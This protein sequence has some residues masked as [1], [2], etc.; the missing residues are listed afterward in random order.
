MKRIAVCGSRGFDDYDLAGEH[1]MECLN[2]EG[3]YTDIVIV[4]IYLF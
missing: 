3:V 4:S 1:N 2:I